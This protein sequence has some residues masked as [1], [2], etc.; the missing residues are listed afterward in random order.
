[1]LID[2]EIN[3]KA[4]FYFYKLTDILKVIHVWLK[5]NFHK[6]HIDVFTSFYSFLVHEYSI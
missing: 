3:K 2:S 6:V 1:M 5:W 4:A